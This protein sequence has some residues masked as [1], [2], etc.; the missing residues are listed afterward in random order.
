MRIKLGT[1][2]SNSVSMTDFTAP[3]AQSRASTGRPMSRFFHHIP[4]IRQVFI[5]QLL[6]HLRQGPVINRHIHLANRIAPGPDTDVEVGPASRFDGDRLYG[7]ANEDAVDDIIDD[8]L[9]LSG[10]A[11]NIIAVW[12]R[13]T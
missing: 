2:A 6:P 4:S 5:D 11:G 1:L 8:S 13:K 12:L 7:V 9:I 10:T 3:F